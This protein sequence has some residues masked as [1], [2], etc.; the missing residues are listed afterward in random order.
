MLGYAARTFGEQKALGRRDIADVQDRKEVE[1]KTRRYFEL[2]DY[3]Y[4]SY[5][6]ME[7]QVL[8]LACARGVHD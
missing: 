7:A 8:T 2:D 3:K 5:M 4:H 1:A 6:E